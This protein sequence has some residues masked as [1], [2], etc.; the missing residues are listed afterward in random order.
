MIVVLVCIWKKDFYGESDEAEA[1]HVVSV[2][3]V[4]FALK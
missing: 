2:T 4:L 1:F 3:S